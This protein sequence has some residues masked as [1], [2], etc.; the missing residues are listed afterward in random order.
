MNFGEG[1]GVLR[2]CIREISCACASG[3]ELRTSDEGNA[4]IAQSFT[5]LHLYFTTFSVGL[6]RFTSVVELLA[7]S[8]GGWGDSGG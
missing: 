3:V 2:G 6:P 5:P 1:A 4:A 7:P 8:A